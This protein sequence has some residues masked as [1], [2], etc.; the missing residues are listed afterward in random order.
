[1]TAA[2]DVLAVVVA[3]ATLGVLARTVRR[4]P[5]V[6]VVPV[7]VATVDVAA[8]AIVMALVSD[9]LALAVAQRVFGWCAIGV[10]VWLA[11]R[12]SG[13]AHLTGRRLLAL[14]ALVPVLELVALAVPATRGRVLDPS[15]QGVLAGPLFGVD[16]AAVAVVLTVSSA[17]LLVVGS[18]TTPGQRRMLLWIVASAAP[19]AGAWVLYSLGH[20]RAT[21]TPTLVSAAVGGWLLVGSRRPGLVQLPITVPRVLAG[22]GE[23]VVV[24]A[25]SGEILSANAAAWDLL[26]SG[27]RSWTT[28]ADARLGPPPEPGTAVEVRTADGRMVELLAARLDQPGRAPTVVVTARDI[29]ELAD[30]REHLQDVASR[31]AMTGA[32]NRRYLDSRLPEMVER[33]RG[34]F[35]L[36][37]VMLDVDRFKHVND[38][39]GHAMGDRV[40][41]GVADEAH[42]SLPAGAELVRLGGDEFA[43]VLPGMDLEA[44]RRAGERI[45]ARCAELQFATRAVPLSVTV[46]VG[47]AQ[48]EPG[49]SADA[50][51]AAA[52]QA[53]YTVKRAHQAA[54]VPQQSPPPSPSAPIPV[55]PWSPPRE[56]PPW[57][58]RP[59]APG[60]RRYRDRR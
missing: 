43:A 9:P 12:A 42:A 54:F 10:L 47:V 31:D 32:R 15:G 24:M 48:A 35:A 39:Y 41:V 19:A 45:A 60:M 40:I 59:P 34:R 56:D 25:A 57:A 22:I 58:N 27:L 6:M 50:L 16:T 44:A 33:A 38:T 11:L 51:L 3:V 20:G 8:W 13:W 37:V 18:A 7:V 46:S 49:M 4:L 21:W 23:G 14:G 52:D 1:M 28:Y 53:L 2:S 26:A 5:R 29:T 36:S 55:V 30:A 17:V